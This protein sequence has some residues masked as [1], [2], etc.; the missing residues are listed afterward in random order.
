MKLAIFETF[1]TSDED[2]KDQ[3][4]HPV[5]VKTNVDNCTKIILNY[6]HNNSYYNIKNEQDYN[7][8]FGILDDYE[9][10][11]HLIK[12]LDGKI[13]IGVSIYSPFHRGRT[14]SRVRLINKDM[15]ELFKNYL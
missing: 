8:I 3:T 9:T 15:Q 5:K 1:S 14:R 13:T 11:I 12:E 7:E 10:T 6:F 2:S 4:L